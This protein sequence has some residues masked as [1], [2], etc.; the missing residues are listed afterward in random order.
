M[1]QEVKITIYFE[2]SPPAGLSSFVRPGFSWSPLIASLGVVV[3]QAGG[4]A[5]RTLEAP[6]FLAPP[7]YSRSRLEVPR[8]LGSVN[9]EP[10]AVITVTV[11]NIFAAG[12]ELKSARLPPRLRLKNATALWAA[13]IQTNHGVRQR[14]L[15]HFI[16]FAF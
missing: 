4:T 12:I 7:V 13:Y 1:G 11:A 16:I 3:L 15:H 5:G 8:G 14:K 10:A 9:Q 6:Q 2:K